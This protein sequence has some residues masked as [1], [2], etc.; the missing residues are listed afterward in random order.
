M[1]VEQNGNTR[2]TVWVTPAGDLIEAYAKTE[3][4]TIEDGIEVSR[5]LAP[6]EQMLDPSHLAALLPMARVIEEHRSLTAYR[7]DA[8]ERIAL[9]EAQAAAEVENEGERNGPASTA[10]PSR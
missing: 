6:E 9:L 1:R 8:D 2:L 10:G 5:E 7:Q 4:V 3:R